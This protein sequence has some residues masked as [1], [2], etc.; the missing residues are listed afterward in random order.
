MLYLLKKK[1]NRK[2]KEFR[3]NYQHVR[4]YNGTE[5]VLFLS[6]KRSTKVRTYLNLIFRLQQQYQQP[7]VIEF[8]LFRYFVLV[9]WFKELDFIYF[10]KPFQK[11]KMYR[12]F[13]HK[14][15][16]DFPINFKYKK[17][18]A[19]DE[20]VKEAVPYIMHP[21]NYMIAKPELLEKQVGI[22]MS[23][24][25]EAK[26]YDSDTITK[27]FN[28][29]NRWQI[30]NQIIQHTAVVSITGIEFKE[31]FSSCVFLDKFV[32]MKWQQG[33]IPSEEWRHYLS[34]AKFLFCAPGMTMPMCHNVVE[35]MSV[36]VVPIINYQNWLNPTLRD[37][38]NA[39][40]YESEE[41]I[42]QVI[43]KALQMSYTAYQELQ[44][45]VIDYYKTFY[46]DYDFESNRNKTLILLNEDSKDLI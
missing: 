45:N 29:L 37:E 17:V 14:K 33:A 21:R 26:I 35:A 30:Y 23:G 4:F 27:N 32:V 36:G 18:Y 24:N 2:L 15:S 1:I 31:Q 16:A 9:K 44:K 8:S 42:H 11:P 43:D 28:L 19:T 39:L 13:S 41:S 34:S 10:S 46:Q 22:V 3:E 38:K 6:L 7:I 20:Y 12:L 25:F 40:V 5:E